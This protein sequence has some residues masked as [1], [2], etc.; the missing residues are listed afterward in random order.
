MIIK[1]YND[2]H[3]DMAFS[4]METQ[5]CVNGVAQKRKIPSTIAHGTVY[6]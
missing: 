3:A 2:V 1:Y 5:R 4:L 6:V